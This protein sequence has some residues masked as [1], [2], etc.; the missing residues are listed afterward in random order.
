MDENDALI[1]K[2]LYIVSST[3]YNKLGE[4]FE[5]K[6]VSR[7]KLMKLIQLMLKGQ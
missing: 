7:L 6:T 5:G 1:D 3:F 2:H 4:I